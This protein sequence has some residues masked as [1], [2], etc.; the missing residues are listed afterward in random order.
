MGGATPV[1]D[2]RAVAEICGVT[3]MTVSNWM[4]DSKQGR[5]YAGNPFPAPDGYIG[6]SPW[7]DPKRRDEF[8][9]WMT[10]R[11]GR[12]VGGGRPPKRAD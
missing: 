6:K 2:L 4:S 5:R 11:P 7:W 9:A 10:A 8:G 3:A 12:G 1:L